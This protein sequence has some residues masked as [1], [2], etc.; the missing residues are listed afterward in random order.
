MCPRAAR[1]A[2]PSLAVSSISEGSLEEI[3]EAGFFPPERERDQNNNKKSEFPSAEFTRERAA[4]FHRNGKLREG[5]LQHV[6]LAAELC[7]VRFVHGRTGCGA[8]PRRAAG[9]G[10][11]YL[12]KSTQMTHTTR[13]RCLSLWCRA[14]GLQP[15]LPQAFGSA[16]KPTKPFKG[17]RGEGMHHLLHCWR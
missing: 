5:F 12:F 6:S 1:A 14:G 7:G 13:T 17:I 9:W 2:F 11:L 8:A 15:C 3:W 10:E 4:G 16:G